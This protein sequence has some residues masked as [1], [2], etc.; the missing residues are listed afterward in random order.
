MLHQFLVVFVQR[1]LLYVAH[2]VAFLQ[3]KKRSGTVYFRGLCFGYWDCV[4]RLFSPNLEGTVKSGFFSLRL[5]NSR[6]QK[7][8]LKNFLRK[9]QV[10]C[11]QKLKKS[12]ILET[13]LAEK[14]KF[15]K[16]ME[17]FDEIS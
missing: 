16:K 17:V 4:V 13:I 3:N 5:K 2:S 14:S 8:K 12:E 15:P 11:V 1:N 7:L 10:F 6:A 9:T